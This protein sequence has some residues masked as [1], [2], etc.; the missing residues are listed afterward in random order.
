MRV[1]VALLVAALFSVAATSRAQLSVHTISRTRLTVGEGSR[2]RDIRWCSATEVCVALGRNGVIRTA[3]GNARSSSVIMPPGA[4]GG[5][6]VSSRLA[7]SNNYILVGSSMGQY[8]WLPL[9]PASA[10]KVEQRGLLTLVDL[11]ARGDAVAILGAA[12][13][14]VQGLARDGAIAWSGSFSSNLADLQILMTGR[15]KPGAK[16]MARCGILETGA[17]R[18][19]LDGSIV[20]MPG[21]EPGIFRFEAG[22]LVQTW[23]TGRFGLVDDCS[24]DEFTIRELAADFARRS[25]WLASQI[26]LEDIV[27]MRSA[28]GLLLRHVGR[29]LTRWELVVL[30]FNGNPERVVLPLTHASPQAHVRGDVRGNRLVLLL[31]DAPLPGQEAKPSEIIVMG[32]S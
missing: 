26:V 32:L 20:V 27:P 10:A 21:V 17:I 25:E 2:P 8:G 5:F 22:R 16:D 13:G 6:P 4:R 7:M 28:A 15:T 11:D 23:D 9:A 14:D 18:F 19:M 31:F 29:G 12:S 3:A 30:P 1:R 24:V